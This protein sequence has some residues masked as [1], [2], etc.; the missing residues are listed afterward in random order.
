MQY[1][2]RLPFPYIALMMSLSVPAFAQSDVGE[3]TVMQPISTDT[4]P[5]QNPYAELDA[6]SLKGWDT[7][8]P[9]IG[10]TMLRDVGGV[11]SSLAEAGIG[12]LGLSVNSFTYNFRDDNRPKNPQV[13]NGQKPTYNLGLQTLF[14]T[15]DA[16]RIGLDGG[17]FFV[18]GTKSTNGFQAVN[19]PRD[20]R[21]VNLGY[22]Q[23]LAGGAV[24]IKAG[25]FD[26]SQE[27]YGAT[28]GGSVA[29]GGLGPQA[30]IPV[31]VG[32]GANGF[33][34]PALN[35]RFNAKNHTY[36]KVGVQR[37]LAPGGF[38]P[39]LAAN[40]SGLGFSVPHAKA[41]FVG[42]GGYNE[43][44]APGVRATWVRG[45]GI[46]NT[47]DYT[48]FRDGK[49]VDNWAVFLAA[50]RQ[51]TQNDQTLPFRGVY[52]GAS[53][54]Y[55]PSRQNLYSQYY[56][57]RI[58]GIG[59]L[60]GRPFDLAS[61][62]ASYTGLSK[63][64]LNAIVPAGQAGDR[65]TTTVVGSYALQVMPGFYFQPGVGVVVHPTYYPKVRTAFNGYL[66]LTFI[67]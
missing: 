46:Y 22:Y 19:G 60:E 58:Y 37:S 59:L 47:S 62:V 16:G 23:K 48:R 34:T 25:V 24:E 65:S 4:A 56:E 54:N 64:G 42:E 35:V 15:F 13:Y 51:L 28:V 10:D 50:D 61:I 27:Y 63:S 21:I 31:Q 53:F 12:I 45:G 26:N 30:R 49:S 40:G 7:P 33:G 66:G 44:A 11:R 5:P 39:E 57:G 36:L 32:L 41:L 18:A 55:A 9:A 8:F 20:A 17:Q 1:V 43:P 67:L 2:L 14:V 29:T 3:G 6:L 52:V 38:V